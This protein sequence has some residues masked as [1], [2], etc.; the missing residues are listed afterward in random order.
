MK[1]SVRAHATAVGLVAVASL[2]GLLGWYA[3]RVQQSQR[4]DQTTAG[5]RRRVRTTPA[6]E[7]HTGSSQRMFS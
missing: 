3:V 7:E 4:T 2:G 1:N 6:P 5:T